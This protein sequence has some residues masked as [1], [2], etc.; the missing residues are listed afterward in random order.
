MGVFK[1]A[2]T[3]GSEAGPYLSV[4][5]SRSQ[6]HVPSREHL[7]ESG[8]DAGGHLPTFKQKGTKGR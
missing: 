2:V 7:L 5:S 6:A 1:T 3:G 4:I 8:E